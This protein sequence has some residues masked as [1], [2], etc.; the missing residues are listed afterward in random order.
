MNLEH[1][2]FQKTS[3]WYILVIWPVTRYFMTIFDKIFKEEIIIMF[4]II[5]IFM[6]ITGFQMK[7]FSIFNCLLFSI[8]YN[9]IQL[10]LVRNYLDK[11]ISHHFKT[12]YTAI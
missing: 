10:L 11:D 7:Q 1:I 4:N 12:L 6:E 2:T 5:Y 9:I 8:F 3:S